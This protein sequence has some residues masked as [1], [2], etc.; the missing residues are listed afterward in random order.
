MAVLS[1]PNKS[2]E[3]LDNNTEYTVVVFMLLWWTQPKRSYLAKLYR[4][5]LAV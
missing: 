1:F 3:V 4:Q 2:C 5:V